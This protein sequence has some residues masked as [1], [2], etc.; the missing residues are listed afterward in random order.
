MCYTELHY[1]TVCKG[2]QPGKRVWITIQYNI[3]N[4]TVVQD[5]F[6]R[7][8]WFIC[9]V[10]TPLALTLI[11]TLAT[12]CHIVENESNLIL[13]SKLNLVILK[14]HSWWFTS[15]VVMLANYERC[16]C[17]WCAAGGP[18]CAWLACHNYCRYGRQRDRN[19]CGSCACRRR[20]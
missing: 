3:Y 14:R 5:I 7:S 8:F 16:V 13:C 18:P 4:D 9:I 17:C 1:E 6:C 20:P 12:Q 11:L 19:G 15:R 2:C 10:N